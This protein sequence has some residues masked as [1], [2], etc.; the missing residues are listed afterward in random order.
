MCVSFV[1]VAS[2]FKLSECRHGGEGSFSLSRSQQ[3]R[4][5]EERSAVHSQLMLSQLS[6]QRRNAN[7]SKIRRMCV[8]ELKHV[9][10]CE[11]ARWTI[12]IW[13][14][15][16]HR[17]AIILPWGGMRIK[18]SRQI[19]MAPRGKNHHHN[20]H[21][22]ANNTTLNTCTHNLCWVQCCRLYGITFQKITYKQHCNTT[23]LWPIID[24][25]VYILL[26]I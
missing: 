5:V 16:P 11:Q 17:F 22:L 7:V 20:T 13:G 12:I 21:T 2:G 25:F 8:V 1:W 10:C 6:Q 23:E 19:V 9:I 15:V 26:L 18:L 3:A 14:A 4:D 24:I